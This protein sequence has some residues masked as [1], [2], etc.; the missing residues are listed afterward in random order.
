MLETLLVIVVV[1]LIFFWLFNMLMANV[2]GDPK[3][4]QIVYVI[5]IALAILYFLKRVNIL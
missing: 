1:L 4:K 2:G 5:V 3:L